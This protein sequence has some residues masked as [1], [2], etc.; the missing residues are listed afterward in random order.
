M[1][2]DPFLSPA[3]CWGGMIALTAISER[4]NAYLSHCV[5][6]Q[7]GE[8]LLARYDLLAAEAE[9]GAG[10]LYLDLTQQPYERMQDQLEGVAAHNIARALMEGIA[11]LTRSRIERMSRLG[12]R[13]TGR[14]VLTGGP[15]NSPVWPGIIADVLNAPVTL[16]ET[17]QYAGAMGA[18]IFAG[19]GGGVFRDERDGYERVR[20]RERIIAPDPVRSSLYHGIYDDYSEHFQLN[21]S[22][23][24]K[25][26]A[27]EPEESAAEV[28]VFRDQRE[29]LHIR[30]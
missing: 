6:P 20:S 4:M 5:V 21:N 9:P 30:G 7:D 10:G 2:V 28:A 1:L 11:F 24:E 23:G 19:M 16:P 8:T 29:E 18:V 15:A 3:G 17:G 22:D 14:I 27:S 12:G 25:Y 26:A 13:S